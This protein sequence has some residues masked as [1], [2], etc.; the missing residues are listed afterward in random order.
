[1]MLDVFQH[2]FSERGCKNF[3][4]SVT[5]ESSFGL[6]F[7][8]LEQSRQKSA[9]EESSTLVYNVPILPPRLSILD[10]QL[11]IHHHTRL[12]PEGPRLKDRNLLVEK[13]TVGICYSAILVQYRFFTLLD[14]A[15][16]LL[17][18]SLFDVLIEEP[19]CNFG[20]WLTHLFRQLY[21]LCNY[22]AT[23]LCLSPRFE[24]E[25]QIVFVFL[26]LPSP[27]EAAH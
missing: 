22:V 2:E 9:Q 7:I 13:L 20:D 5:I 8:I 23:L 19:P 6:L 17:G 14:L 27:F 10:A 3:M 26:L 16:L 1:M 18:K 15:C 11:A 4:V 21:I 25:V 24:E 12:I